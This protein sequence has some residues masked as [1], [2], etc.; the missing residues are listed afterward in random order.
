M[1][2]YSADIDE[3]EAGTDMCH[4][5]RADCTNTIGSY[6]CICKVGYIG[7]GINCTGKSSE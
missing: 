7:D 2:L 5:S 3:C 6:N 1:S 4:Q